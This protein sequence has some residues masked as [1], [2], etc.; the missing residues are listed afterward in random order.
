[1][2]NG[3][4]RQGIVH[5]LDKETSG[6]IVIARNDVAQRRLAKQFQDR[7]VDKTY[8]AL[9]ERTPKTL[10]GRIEAPIGRDHQQRKRMAVVR[11]GKPAIT[12]YRVTDT[13]FR[14][15]QALVEVHILTGRT[16]QIRVHMAFIGSPVVGDT[17]YG[18]RKQRVSM[19]RH[20]LHAARLEFNHPTNGER[21]KFESP[22]P[23]VLKD[24]L[25]KLR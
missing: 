1:M 5:R 21:L 14:E 19:K 18:F 6:L 12:E 20:F 8:V 25:E 10:T 13:E 2:Q 4:G 24:T 22:L 9:V 15:G 3:E 7:T 16:H 11:E 23:P 17:V